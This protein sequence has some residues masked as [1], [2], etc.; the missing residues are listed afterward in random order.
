[1]STSTKGGRKRI[2]LNSGADFVFFLFQ[3]FKLRTNVSRQIWYMVV[4]LV[5]LQGSATLLAR[6]WSGGP[7]TGTGRCGCSPLLRHCLN[8]AIAPPMMLLGSAI[9]YEFPF[10]LPHHDH[11]DNW[12]RVSFSVY[13]YSSTSPDP[14]HLRRQQKHR[15]LGVVTRTEGLT[16]RFSSNG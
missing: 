2:S 8:M 13:F 6:G 1:M 14:L 9:S 10:S 15:A 11:D 12:S 7:A 4:G 16:V 3:R 5:S